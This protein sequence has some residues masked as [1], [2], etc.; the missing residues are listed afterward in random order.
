L[1]AVRWS[2]PNVLVI[3]LQM[4]RKNGLAVLRELQAEDCRRGRWS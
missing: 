4:P 1:Q 3:D 2:R